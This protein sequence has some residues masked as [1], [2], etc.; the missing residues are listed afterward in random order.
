[1][2][3]LATR[4]ETLP[5]N[6]KD[7]TKYVLFGREKLT[8]VRAE[9]KA[10]EKL[11]VATD[12]RNIKKTEAQSLAGLLLYAEV[13]L[14]ELF[15]KMPKAPGKRT[16]SPTSSHRNEEV[17][18]KEQ[19]V[20]ELGFNTSQV[21]HF[22]K[23]KDNKDVVED[24]I[25]EAEEND[26]LPTRTEVLRRVKINNRVG[27]LEKQKAQI[28]KNNISSV[29]GFYD[30]II[31]DPPWNYGDDYDPITR[32]GTVDYP[33]MSIEQIKDLAMPHQKD[34][35]LWLWTTQKHICYAFDI[36]KYW[37][38][39]YK[40]TLTWVKNKM[41]LGKWLRSKTEFCIL[42][43]KGKPYFNLTNQTTVLSADVRE[44]SRKPDE[45]YDMVK[46][47]NT[48]R[49]LDY[50]SREKRDGFDSYGNDITKF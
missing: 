46:K 16:D 2:I 35:C 34:C 43:I 6:I 37:G 50:F 8:S 41:G 19:A 9:M 31:I 15:A 14:G 36:L 18:T 4:D 28:N 24:V 47:L 1:M 40:V 7:L 21:N 20:K 49:M 45:F 44:H 32:R 39:E 27:D 22:E 29:S 13:R 26:D 23:L 48:G 10:M 33:T 17:K 5:E 3:E 42:G 30:V 38:F 25:T 12:V 11:D